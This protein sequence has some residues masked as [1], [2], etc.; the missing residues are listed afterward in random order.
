MLRESTL[1]S[2]CTVT[3]DYIN[4]CVES[5]IPTKTVRVYLNNKTYV[6]K[7][8]K[9]IINELKLA[10]KQ[11]DTQELRRKDKELRGKI[12]KAKDTHKKHLEELFQANDSRKMWSAMKNMAGMPSK[13]HKPFITT[14]ELASAVELNSFFIWFEVS[15]TEERCTDILKSVIVHPDRVHISVVQ[16]AQAFRHLNSQKSTG[17]DTDN[18]TASLL[19][20]NSE[21]LAHVW[22]PIF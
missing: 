6:T 16:V 14:D 13:Q 12:R 19:K 21:E 18:I 3:T 15:S 4:V 9:Q 7:D 8:I 1:D 22:Q 10:Y 11:K 5:I 17:P 2:A 20:T